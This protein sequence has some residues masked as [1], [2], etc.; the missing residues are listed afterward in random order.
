MLFIILYSSLMEALRGASIQFAAL[1]F[2]TLRTMPRR[3]GRLL[4]EVSEDLVVQWSVYLS[5]F[6]LDGSFGGLVFMFLIINL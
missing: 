3:L 4:N 6:I 5:V 1:R 2:R